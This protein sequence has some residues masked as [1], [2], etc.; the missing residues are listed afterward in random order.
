MESSPRRTGYSV[1]R[2]WLGGENI[3]DCFLGEGTTFLARQAVAMP[4]WRESVSERRFV[5][6]RIESQQLGS[7]PRSTYLFFG[8]RRPSRMVTGLA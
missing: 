3:P 5:K 6:S 4:P 1:W 2:G 7:L 8:W